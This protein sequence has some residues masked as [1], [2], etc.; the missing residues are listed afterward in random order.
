MSDFINQI[1]FICFFFSP[2][3][4]PLL[5]SGFSSG[6]GTLPSAMAEIREFQLCNIQ[7]QYVFLRVP[8]LVGLYL[9]F[10]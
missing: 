8:S 4:V 3:E 5:G 7:Y 10:F 2:V 6:G 1:F 9:F